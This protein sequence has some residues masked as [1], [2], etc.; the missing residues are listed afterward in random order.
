MNDYFLIFFAITG[1][2]VC[3]SLTV[4]STVVYLTSREPHPPL[5]K[6][7]PEALEELEPGEAEVTD[8]GKQPSGTD[9]KVAA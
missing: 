7:L 3:L 1:T 8:S 9:Q 5:P 4:F 6:P 2:A